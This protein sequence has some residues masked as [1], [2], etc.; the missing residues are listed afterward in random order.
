M[1]DLSFFPH[2]SPPPPLFLQKQHH[3]DSTDH[4]PRPRTPSPL[5]D[6][7]LWCF[8]DRECE[9][10]SPAPPPDSVLAASCPRGAR[11]CL[12][13]PVPATAQSC[14]HLG[15][16]VCLFWVQHKAAHFPADRATFS[17]SSFI[18]SKGGVWGL[19]VPFSCSYFSIGSECGWGKTRVLFIGSR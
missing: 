11:F 16:R 4:S 13:P 3:L 9:D 19:H 8:W 6:R 18:F 10:S 14:L 2:I 5:S 7:A 17:T 15:R 1:L 12:V